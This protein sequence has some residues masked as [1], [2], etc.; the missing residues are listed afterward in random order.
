MFCHVFCD[1]LSGLAED[2]KAGHEVI[3][4]FACSTHL[5]MKSQVLIKNVG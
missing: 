4:Y 2:K 5:S 3:K 1:F